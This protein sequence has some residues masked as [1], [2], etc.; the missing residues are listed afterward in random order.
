MITDMNK[1]DESI[2]SALYMHKVRR[3]DSDLQIQAYDIQ[4]SV[5]AVVPVLNLQL[6]RNYMYE[7]F[8]VARR[9]LSRQKEKDEWRWRRKGQREEESKARSST[10]HAARCL[11]LIRPTQRTRHRCRVAWF[12]VFASLHLWMCSTSSTQVHMCVFDGTFFAS[13]GTRLLK[14]TRR[15]NAYA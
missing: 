9:E 11:H 10:T 7:D 13:I 14:G 2:F 4:E 1:L 12:L 5:V 6:I 8:G 3:L 15:N